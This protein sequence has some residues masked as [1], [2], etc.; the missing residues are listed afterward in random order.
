MRLDGIF[1][2]ITTTYYRSSDQ[3]CKIAD[4]FTLARQ[5][6]ADPNQTSNV[7]LIDRPTFE[8]TFRSAPTKQAATLFEER[9]T[10]ATARQLY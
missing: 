4:A 6:A 5:T 10:K 2:G 8:K 7:A 9:Q 3:I 1:A